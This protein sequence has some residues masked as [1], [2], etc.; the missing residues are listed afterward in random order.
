MELR[1]QNVDFAFERLISTSLM[2]HQ[3]IAKNANTRANITFLIIFYSHCVK[4][5]IKKFNHIKYDY[6]NKCNATDCDID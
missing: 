5:T 2:H 1:E 3:A 4:K 6:C